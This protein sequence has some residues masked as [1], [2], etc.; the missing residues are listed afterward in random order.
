MNAYQKQIFQQRV[1]EFS[2]FMSQEI[3]GEIRDASVMTNSIVQDISHA[4]NTRVNDF[5]VFAEQKL[6]ALK[7]NAAEFPALLDKAL[8]KLRA[9][10]LNIPE[11]A[12]VAPKPD[13]P[14]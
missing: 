2:R 1:Q 10:R 9:L 12:P 7:T 6:M 8:E 13:A 14:K 5:E 3:A 11:A 4:P